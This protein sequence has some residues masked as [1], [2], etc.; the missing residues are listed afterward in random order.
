MVSN[1]KLSTVVPATASDENNVHELTKMDLVMKLH[2]IHGV[3]FFTSEAVQGLS[4]QDL[5]KPMFP[6]LDLYFMASGRVRRSETG[7]PFI[8]CNDSGVRIVEAKSDKT[9]DEA[10]AMEDHS[11]LDGLAYHLALGPDLSFSP[12]VFIQVTNLTLLVICFTLVA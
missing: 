4:I 5:K 3:Y 1:I 10:L 9:I 6:L 8:K 7:K 2:Y 12:L 11:L